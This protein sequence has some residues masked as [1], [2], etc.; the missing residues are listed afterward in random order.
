MSASDFKPFG[1]SQQDLELARRIASETIERY[2]D[3]DEAY[4]KMFRE[5]GIWNDHVSVQTAI[6]VI[7]HLRAQGAKMREAL[8]PEH[9]RWC[10]P[11]F[12]NAHNIEILCRKDGRTN[13]YEGDWLKDVARTLV[14]CVR[15]AQG[16]KLIGNDHVY[17]TSR[18][19]QETEHFEPCRARS[20]IS[21]SEG[22][23]EKGKQ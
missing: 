16:F 18:G 5:G 22:Q 21:E 20:A 12:R 2:G 14:P 13:V 17:Y 11:R 1:V 19:N 9:E 23:Q 7:K 15:C 3:F 6:S 8:L 10:D 4:W